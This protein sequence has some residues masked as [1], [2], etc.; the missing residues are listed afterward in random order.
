MSLEQLQIFQACCHARI[1]ASQKKSS[2][3]HHLLEEVVTLY[4]QSLPA[5]PFLSMLVFFPVSLESAASLA[6][7]VIFKYTEEAMDE[8]L[9]SY[10]SFKPAVMQE[11]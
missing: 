4:F 9:N 8:T 3:F 1:L 11:F 6:H 5:R 2:K 10:R 7:K